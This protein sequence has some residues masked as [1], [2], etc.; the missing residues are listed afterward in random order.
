VPDHVALNEI[1]GTV[2]ISGRLMVGL[3][4]NVC[5]ILL[6]WPVDEEIDWDDNRTS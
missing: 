3:W 1:Q 6:T 5:H 2:S 4:G